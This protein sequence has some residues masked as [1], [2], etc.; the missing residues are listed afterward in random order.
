MPTLKEIKGYEKSKR[1]G[2]KWLEGLEKLSS[3]LYNF[4]PYAFVINSNS[5]SLY[6]RIPI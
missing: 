4:Q 2:E 6:I 5:N 1:Y 3:Y